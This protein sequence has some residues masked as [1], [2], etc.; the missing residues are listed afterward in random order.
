MKKWI[1][2][3]VIVA[4]F[5]TA[6]AFIGPFKSKEKFAIIL[7]ADT[8]RHEGLARA[9]HAMLYSK[10]LIENG[11]KVVLIFDGAGTHWAEELSRPEGKNPLIPQYVQLKKLGMTEVICDFCANAFAVRKDLTERGLGLVGEY[12]GHPSFVKLVDEGYQ[13]IIL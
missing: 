9:A 6:T 4:T 12:E 5:F 3:V 10:E 2:L 7:Q 1:P 11:H 13:I 8:D